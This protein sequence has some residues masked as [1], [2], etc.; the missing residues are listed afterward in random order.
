MT[1][2][3]RLAVI[4][5]AHKV[6]NFPFAQEAIALLYGERKKWLWRVAHGAGWSLLL[7]IVIGMYAQR[8]QLNS[9]QETTAAWYQDCKDRHPAGPKITNKA[10][11]QVAVSRQEKE[12]E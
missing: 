7:G 1:L 8:P 10:A 9:I 6:Q 2:P 5:L 11:A 4:F 12:R 3:R